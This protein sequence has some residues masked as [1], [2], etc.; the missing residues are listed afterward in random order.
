MTQL[1]VSIGDVGR[2]CPY[3]RFP[4][5][6]STM[7]ERC[8]VCGAMHHTDCWNDGGGCAVVGCRNGP[9]KVPA[10]PTTAAPQ[11]GAWAAPTAQHA[12]SLAEPPGYPGAA[13]NAP[14]APPWATSGSGYPTPNQAPRGGIHLSARTLLLLV[15]V[16]VAGITTGALATG[17]A[18]SNRS[19]DTQQTGAQHGRSTGTSLPG[20]NPTPTPTEATRDRSEI[21]SLLGNYQTAYS[22]HDVNGLA[23]IFTAGVV[24]HGLAATGCAVSRGQHAVLANYASQFEQGSGTYRLVDLTA[25]DIKLRGTDRAHVNAN[26]EITPGGTGYVNFTFAALDGRWKIS[27]VYATC[28]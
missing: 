12:L 4:L 28:H 18:F 11:A 8:D 22:A 5:K 9:A 3:C 15:V 19:T 6:Q 25:G 13:P 21:M 10:T 16:A 14:P 24:R 26:Y 23:Q 7:A 1:L 27:Q 20:V 17:G 2:N